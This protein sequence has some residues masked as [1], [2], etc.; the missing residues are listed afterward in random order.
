MI[1]H[2]SYL[3][4]IAILYTIKQSSYYSKLHVPDCYME[5]MDFKIQLLYRIVKFNYYMEY[6]DYR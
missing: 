1:Q 3:A 2:F 6:D 5:H 4:A